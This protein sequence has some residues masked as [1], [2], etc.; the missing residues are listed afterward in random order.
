VQARRQTAIL[1]A[2][3]PYTATSGWTCQ[4][5][6]ERMARESSDM[7]GKKFQLSLTDSVHL[8]TLRGENC[9]SLRRSGPHHVYNILAA[10]AA[11]QQAWYFENAGLESGIRALE[12]F[13]EDFA[14]DLGQ[15]FLAIV[16]WR[17]KTD[18]ALENWIKKPLTN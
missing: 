1:N 9:K 12:M 7:A 8:R 15:P 4:G 14:L 3:D 18:D 6:L 16:T 5:Q 17:I 10:S 2:D 11:A 13:R